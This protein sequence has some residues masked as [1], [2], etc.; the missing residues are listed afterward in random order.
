M[1]IDTAAGYLCTN[2]LNMWSWFLLKYGWLWQITTDENWFC[3]LAWVFQQLR[4]PRCPLA[5]AAKGAKNAVNG[6]KSEE[7]SPITQKCLFSIPGE[8]APQWCLWVLRLHHGWIVHSWVYSKWYRKERKE[9][10]THFHSL[11]WR[12]RATIGHID[13]TAQ[14]LNP[15]HFVHFALADILA[16]PL[17]SWKLSLFITA[18]F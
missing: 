18:D 5:V 15:W 7:G 11:W 4:A 9:K 3:N 14:T 6:W 16:A 10:K 1:T 2:M 12:F 13:M 17:Y 8:L